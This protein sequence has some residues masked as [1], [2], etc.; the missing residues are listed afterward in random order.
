MF[1]GL[2]KLGK[3]K[4][5]NKRDGNE[6]ETSQTSTDKGTNDERDLKLARDCRELLQVQG[7]VYTGTK[8]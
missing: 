1:D 2:T 7:K 6:Q 3:D 5:E 8:I 4:T